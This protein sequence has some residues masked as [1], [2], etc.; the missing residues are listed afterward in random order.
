MA[1]A[2]DHV[3]LANRN[4]E[5]LT[6]LLATHRQFPEWITVI[7]FYKALHVIDAMLEEDE[8]PT[9]N[10]H[11]RRAEIL[12]SNTRYDAVWDHYRPLCSAASVARY[13][14]EE[15]GKEFTRFADYL[16]ADDVVAKIVRHRL[17]QVEAA[18]LR[19]M[20][21]A[22][23]RLVRAVPPKPPSASAPP[24]GKKP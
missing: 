2:S 12:R 15:K 8:A 6:H 19:L 3:T 17:H 1:S 9:P 24:T 4:Q 21:A 7:A 22:G 23:A 10:D 18:A 16:S 20:P 13:M 14:G 11:K 5:A